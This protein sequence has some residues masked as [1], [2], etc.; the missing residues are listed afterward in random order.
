LTITFIHFF[1]IKIYS[2]DKGVDDVR[3]DVPRPA[4]R[5]P[6]GSGSGLLPFFEKDKNGG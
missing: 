6:L 4:P 1:M 3:D 5:A 2:I